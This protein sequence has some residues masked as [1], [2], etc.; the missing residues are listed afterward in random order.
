MKIT[1]DF[2]IHTHL[3]PCG[4]ESATV[5]NYVANAKK[6]GI[7]KLGFA[8]H[9]WDSNLPALNDFYS[10]Q[11]YEQ[12]A[13]IKDDIKKFDGDGGVKLYFGCECEYDYKNHD[14][15]ITEEIAEKFDY[16]IVPN[17]HTHMTMPK[18]FYEP[19]DKHIE[20]MINSYTDI[21]N[22]RFA[23]YITSIAHPFSAVGCPY[24]ANVLR[25]MISDD[26]YKRLFTMA[27]EKG[28]AIEAC[29]FGLLKKPTNTVD[30]WNPLRPLKL[31]KEC[32]CKFT[33]GS[34]AHDNEYHETYHYADKVA[35]I[36]GLTPD[37][38]AEIAR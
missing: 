19:Y 8:D 31:A 18:D 32:G 4:K 15:A 24:G 12:L 26:T 27:A 1:H 2:H 25:D 38:I 37:D 13:K 10:T 29:V 21:L 33:F 3:S 16:I 36:L 7:K 34:D 6:Y 5:E 23:K 11:G 28:I 35:E 9:F 22:S 14:L 17:S 20:F 30:V